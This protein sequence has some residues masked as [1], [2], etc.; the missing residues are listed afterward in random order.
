VR[1]AITGASG[2]IG[3]ALS[4]RLQTLGQEATAI[5]RRPVG[6]GER[7]VQWDPGAGTIDRDGLEGLDAVVHLAGAGV[8][9]R[10]WSLA[11]KQVVLESRTRSTAFL[12][13]ALAGLADPPRA[14]ISASAVGFYGDRADETVTEQTGPGSDFLAYVCQR[15]EAAA[16]P[17]SEADIRVAFA[18]SGIVLSAHGGALGKLLPMFRLG[19]GGRFGTGSQWWS[20]ITLD[21]EVGALLWLLDHDQAGPVNLTAPNPVTNREFTRVLGQ[22]LSRP[23]VLP[24]PRFGPRLLLGAELAEALLFTSAKVVPAVLEKG[25]YNFTDTDLEP[26]LR[27]L[28]RP[29]G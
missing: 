13:Q 1:V 4:A 28:L 17:A 10:R 12:A 9:D 8:G 5:V 29:A 2:L 21:D 16:G 18:R 22:V 7:A 23:A 25:G 6:R 24:V 26:G 27:R 20:W 19:L 14:L 3:S 11:R 15:W